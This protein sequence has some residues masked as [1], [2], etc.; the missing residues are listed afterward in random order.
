MPESKEWWGADEDGDV[1]WKTG[2]DAKK[3][4]IDVYIAW[5]LTPAG[6]REPSSKAKLAEE[7]GVTAQTL[8][9][10]QK[11]PTFL[12]RLQDDARAHARVDRVPD[13]LEALYNQATD[14]LNPRSVAAGKAYLDYI[15]KI[16]PLVESDLNVE[17]MDDEQ[18]A[19]LAVKLLQKVS[20]G[21]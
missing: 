21:S 14:P 3:D 16:Q 7:M 18:L 20:D 4:R 13:I 9:N 17:E 12:R 8:R 6:E 11:D 19:S 5:L 10:Y 1:S 2:S 15:E